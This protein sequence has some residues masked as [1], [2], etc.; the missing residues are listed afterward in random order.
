VNEATINLDDVKNSLRELGKQVKHRVAPHPLLAEE[1]PGTETIAVRLI[2]SIVKAYRQAAAA[3]DLGAV[4]MITAE[5]SRSAEHLGD[6]VAPNTTMAPR[7]TGG[8]EGA[9]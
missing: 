1:N 4:I 8:M 2:H 7:K 6:V 9:A 5:L 3:N